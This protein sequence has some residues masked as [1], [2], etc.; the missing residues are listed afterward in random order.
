M[1]STTL[2]SIMLKYASN[3]DDKH[4]KICLIIIMIVAI[5]VRLT[6][7]IINPLISSSPSLSS[8]QGPKLRVGTFADT[9]VYIEGQC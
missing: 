3:H 4:M 9:K 8:S 6:D 5:I 7:M 2:S 1:S